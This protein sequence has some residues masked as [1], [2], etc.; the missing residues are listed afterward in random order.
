MTNQAVQIPVQDLLKADIFELLGMAGIS[1]KQR[2]DISTDMIVTIQNR[3]IARL[4]DSLSADEQD[5]LIDA[6]SE[7]K[8]VEAREIL[9]RNDLSSLETMAVEE[10]LIYKHQLV[11]E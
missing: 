11:N 9:S 4:S 5:A 7:K 10:A 6:L 1:S 8:T 2:Q 3:I